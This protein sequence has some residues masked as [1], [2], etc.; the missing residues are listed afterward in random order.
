M[1]EWT[2]QELR[3]RLETGEPVSVVDIRDAAEHEAWSILGSRNLAVYDALR[4]D[5][6]EPLI[7]KAAELPRDTP[8]I[9]VCRMGVVS[10]KAAAVLRTL[11]F[12]AASLEGGMHDWSG[13]WAEAPIDGRLARGTTLIQIQRL[14]KG[15]LSY[16][17][18]SDGAAVVVDPCVDV[19]AYQTVADREGLRITHVLE[20]HVHAD[21]VSRAGE[22]AQATGAKLVLPPNDRVRFP[23]VPFADGETLRVAERTIRALATPGHTGESTCFL[24]DDRVLLS[25]DTLFVRAFGRPD[26]ERGDAGAEAGARAL[27]RSLRRIFGLGDDVW[28]YPGHH[29]CPIPFDRQPIGARLGDVRPQLAALDLDEDTFARNIVAGLG[30]KPPNFERVLAVNEGRA[31]LGDNEPLDLEAGPNRCAA[32]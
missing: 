26:L 8:V 5:H 17:L 14:G 23:Y 19:S 30:A 1:H 12:D 25:G 3:A 13:V 9:T 11:G 2:C 31:D 15:C 7:R 6:V 4:R 18:G 24:V 28:T 10:R 21:H 29:G 22:L 27:Y 32:S 20:T 16:L